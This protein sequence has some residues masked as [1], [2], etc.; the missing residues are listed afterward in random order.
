MF[1]IENNKIQVFIKNVYGKE[2]IYIKDE[3]IAKIISQL[4]GCKTLTDH[5]IHWL[6][7]IGFEFEVVAERT[8][9]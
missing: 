2:N 1:K 9:L 5:S 6:K 3:A 7:Q 4:T 8:T